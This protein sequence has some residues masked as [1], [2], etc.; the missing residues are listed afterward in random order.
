M[1]KLSEYSPILHQEDNF[2]QSTS[3]DQILAYR[4][5]LPE[6]YSIS[7]KQ[8]DEIHSVWMQTLKKLPKSILLKQDFFSAKEFTG[9][10]MPAD[11]FLQKSMRDFSLGKPYRSHV[12]NLFFINA[13]NRYLKNGHISNPFKKPPS[14]KEIKAQIQKDEE[15]KEQINE[16]IYFLKSSPYFSVGPLKEGY[17]TSIAKLY[18]NGLTS[19]E[20]TDTI[21]KGNN[22]YIG[23]KQVGCYAITS[24]RQL[25]ETVSSCL[26]DANAESD[27]EFYS[28]YFD[29]FGLELPFDHIYNQ[30][31]FFD[32]HN[33]LK[34]E[35]ADQQAWFH[36][37]RQFAPE[38]E[39]ADKD[40]RDYLDEM[41]ADNKIRLVRAHYNITFMA[42]NETKFKAYKAQLKQRFKQ[43][44]ITPYYPTGNNLANIFNNSFFTNVSSLNKPNSFVI[45]L[46]QAVC[47]F[48]AV[49]SFRHDQEGVYFSDRLF[50]LPLKKDVWDAKKRFIK[51]RNF[52]VVAPT[53]E[54]KSFLLNCLI[55]QL[56]D[57]GYYFVINDLGGSF[58]K[59][60]LLY[61]DITLYLQYIPGKP[62]GINPFYVAAGTE[63]DVDKINELVEFVRTLYLREKTITE[64]EKVSIRKLLIFYYKNV[65]ENHSFPNF[66]YF[67][68]FLH[69]EN[70]LSTSLEIDSE[71][72]NAKSF[73]HICSE[74]VG[75]GV[76][77]FLFPEDAPEMNI[78]LTGKRLVINEFDKA[79]DDPLL[80][81][82]LLNLSNSIDRKLIWE[83]KSKRGYILYEECA[84][85]MKFPNVLNTLEWKAQA[86]RKQEGGLGIVLQA[87]SQI[88]E[89]STAQSIIKNIHSFFI[90]NHQNGY[91]EVVKRFNFTEHEHNLLKSITNNFDQDSSIQYSEF[92]HK[93]GR[94]ANVLRL[95]LSKE[96]FYAYMTDGADH[97]ELMKVH[98]KHQDMEKAIKEFIKT[99]EHAA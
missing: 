2:T 60:A 88:P 52:F 16:A 10:G 95:A 15:F 67:V 36:R 6:A 78:D 58:E 27:Y 93:R 70:K 91:E 45:D 99:K 19:G 56:L 71:L 12:C 68:E 34:N 65:K 57:Q 50:N 74:F 29:S 85:M 26:R 73:L 81:S 55:S 53:G 30:I 35:V 28:G 90:L 8:Y 69:K 54:G 79:K 66:Y 9:K 64:E 48:T 18:F 84:K 40:L 89:N 87:P 32:D 11:N 61:P 13:G 83:D 80:V 86:I 59:L 38:N 42:E 76:Y 97:L 37:V 24:N 62:L 98:K 44:D 46:Q 82:I 39:R 23:E 21:R 49:S 4:L 3:G 75:E 7:E 1:M 5:V 92:M 94:N 31:L 41:A 47:L 17:A 96:Q 63:P 33:D 43:L 22:L 25:S 51:A 20:Y 72:F 14:E 77:A